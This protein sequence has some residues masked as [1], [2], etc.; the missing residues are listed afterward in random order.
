MSHV[1]TF[2]SELLADFENAVHATN[3]E[4]LEVEL[5]SDTHE[6]LH[7]K[8]VVVSLEGASGGTTGNHVH[9][10]S[11]D[12]DE[13]LLAQERADEVNDLG[14][15]LEDSL[16]LTVHDEIEVSLSVSGVFVHSDV[17]SAGCIG[18]GQ[19][20]QAVGKQLDGLGS[21][22]ELASV[23][24]AGHTDDADNVTTTK[25]LLESLEVLLVVCS[26]GKDL[27]LGVTLDEV[28]EHELGTRSSQQHDTTGDHNLS[29]VEELTLLNLVVVELGL[30]ILER[31]LS[32]ELVRVRVLVILTDRLQP[33]L[34]H[35][36]VL[37]G[38]EIGLSGRSIFFLFAILLGLSSL[39]SGLLGSIL[40]LLALRVSLLELVLGDPLVGDLVEILF[41]AIS[42]LSAGRLLLVGVRLLELFS[43]V[44]CS[45]GVV[46]RFFGCGFLRFAKLIINLTKFCFKFEL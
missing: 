44:H 5:G 46:E 16:D 31:H 14:A 33:S 25:R 24:L 34:S 4:H 6:Q 10:G 23:G 29:V 7:L 19:L 21:H 45:C 35:L 32:V 30:E 15:S 38:V 2:V 18:L 40:L 39:L 22:G 43:L 42:S 26:V 11:L 27:H 36:G 20:M 37:S 13:L 41:L 3:D 1:D 9:H 12:L 8:L 17:A 28:E